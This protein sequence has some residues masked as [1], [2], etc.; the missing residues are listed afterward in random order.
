MHDSRLLRIFTITAYDVHT[1][2][3]PGSAASTLQ[4]ERLYLGIES[5]YVKQRWLHGGPVRPLQYNLE[6]LSNLIY[7]TWRCQSEQQQRYMDWAENAIK[8]MLRD[9]PVT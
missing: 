3:F 2:R 6:L 8:E 9:E 7:L 5:D 4:A 1:A